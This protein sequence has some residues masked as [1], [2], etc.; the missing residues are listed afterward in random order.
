MESLSVNGLD[1]LHD[2]DVMNINEDYAERPSSDS[3][4]V[5]DYLNNMGYVMEG[6]VMF[7]RMVWL[8]PNLRNELMII[9]SEDLRPTG[10]S[11]PELTNGEN[12]TDKRI[13]LFRILHE[14]ALS[15]F[16]I[17]TN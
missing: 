15:S 1:F 13:Q 14:R 2:A 4:H 3:A 12:T 8:D 10:Y 17:E 16:R 9:Y 7:K 11:I 5:I 6:N